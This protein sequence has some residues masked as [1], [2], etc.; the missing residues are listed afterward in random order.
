[1]IYANHWF[2]LYV[3]RIPIVSYNYHHYVNIKP[4]SS[5]KPWFLYQ[6]EFLSWLNRNWSDWFLEYVPIVVQ[7]IGIWWYSYHKYV[8]HH[9]FTLFRNWSSFKSKIVYARCTCHSWTDNL[10]IRN[11]SGSKTWVLIGVK[12]D[13]SYFLKKYL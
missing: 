13:A 11:L 8:I 2:L 10:D 3:I 5:R 4:N 1:M 7:L 6:I 9:I 12:A